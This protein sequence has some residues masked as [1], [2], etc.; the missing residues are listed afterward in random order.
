[1]NTARRVDYNAR[2]TVRIADGRAYVL[3]RF[4]TR[5]HPPCMFLHSRCSRST[6]RR[7]DVAYRYETV[8][9]AQHSFPEACD[10]VSKWMYRYIS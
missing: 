4:L 9:K 6:K 3:K 7:K 10:R 5:D 2:E 1:M 8:E